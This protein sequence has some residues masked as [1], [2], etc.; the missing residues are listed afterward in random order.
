MYLV[1][2]IPRLTRNTW[3]S[4][5]R[6]CISGTFHGSFVGGEAT[7]MRDRRSRRQIGEYKK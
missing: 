3:P 2:S 6:M 5:C 1:S 7:S 4:G